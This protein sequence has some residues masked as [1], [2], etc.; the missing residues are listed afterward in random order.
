MIGER[1]VTTK[2]ID[3]IIDAII[4]RIEIAGIRLDEAYPNLPISDRNELI[5]IIKDMIE[6]E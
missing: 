4:E 5:D 6:Y 1:M 2:T 3:N